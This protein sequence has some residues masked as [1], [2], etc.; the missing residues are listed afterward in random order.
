[1]E[2]LYCIDIVLLKINYDEEIYPFFN[3]CAA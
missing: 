1:M 2:N 3:A